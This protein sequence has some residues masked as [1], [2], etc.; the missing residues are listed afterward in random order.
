[1]DSTLRSRLRHL[2]GGPRPAVAKGVFRLSPVLLLFALASCSDSPTGPAPGPDIDALF[3]APTAS[4]IA[5]VEAEWTLREVSA[6][7]VQV[8]FDSTLVAEGLRVRVLSHLVDGAR[9][10]GALVTPAAATASG[11][12]SIVVYGHGGDAGTS[13]D[14]ILVVAGLLQG[15][16][17]A[18]AF[19]QPSF[20]D[21]P[22]TFGDRVFQSEGPPS[23]WDRDVDATIAFLSTAIASA[24]ELDAQ[25][26]VVVGQSRGADVGLLTAIRDPRVQA[27]V[28]F[29][30]PTDFFGSYAREIF[31]EALAGTPRDLPGL[32]YLNETV[33]QPWKNG[34]LSTA[35]A[36]LEMVRRSP[37]Y[38]V[39]RL[40]AVQVHHG[41]ADIVVDVSQ[42]ERLIEVMEA[43]GRT[44]PEFEAYLYSGGGHNPFTLEGATERTVA[45]LTPYLTEPPVAIAETRV[46]AGR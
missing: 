8:A 40:P 7:S 35:D 20:P 25:R 44:A 42:T 26:I 11:S 3:A 4:E 46:A 5:A 14:E 41:T 1:M 2:P 29:F 34:D 22:L 24:P 28:E 18:T 16:A 37:V 32:D 13:I 6:Q 31:E 39:D 15:Q 19:V 27:V 12:L 33:I 23:P 45:F 21:E 30:G 43:A 36:R 38:F 17:P 10:Y 9:H